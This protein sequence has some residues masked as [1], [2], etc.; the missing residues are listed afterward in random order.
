VARANAMPTH[1]ADRPHRPAHRRW[2]GAAW[3]CALLP[4]WA[5]AQG[6]AAPVGALPQVPAPLR[7]GLLPL[8]A[9]SGPR[10]APTAPQNAAVAEVVVDVNAQAAMAD[11]VSRIAVSVRLNDAS[12]QPLRTPAM[13]T[14]ESS[15]GRILLPGAGTDESGPGGL[16]ADRITPGVQVLVEGGRANFWLIAPGRPQDVLLRVSA[17]AAVAEG[18]VR[19]APELREMVAAGLV[20]GVIAMRNNAGSSIQPVRINDGFEQ[21]I[22]NWARSFDNDKGAAA[23][24]AAFFLKGKIKGDALL[25]MAYDSD[26]ETQTRLFRDVLPDQFYPVYGDASIKGSDAQS[27][28]KLYVRIDKDRNYLLY[29]DFITSASF[30]PLATPLT[31]PLSGPLNGLVRGSGLMRLRDLGNYSRTVTG[32]QAH[33]EDDRG[34][35]NAFAVNQ[36][37]RVAIEEYAANGTSGPFAVRNSAAV[38]NSEKVELITRD[39]NN[40][41]LILRSVPLAPL[42]DYVF[43][44]FSGRILLTRPLPS[45]DEVGNP[46]SLR[47]T[48]EVEQGGNPFWVYGVDGQYRV[49]P[50]LELGGSFVD[51]RNP[52]APYRLGSVNT[53]VRIGPNTQL[54][55]ELARS[56]GRYN[57]GTGVD[58][59]L[60]PGL[61][62]VSGEAAGNAA[63]IA[64][65]HDDGTTAV[66]L[67][68]GRSQK[69]FDNP[70]ASYNGGRSDA[71][72]RAT[73]RL[74]P[75]TTLFG[76]AVRTENV[77]AGGV[78]DGAQVGGAFRLSDK[79]SVDVALK[80]LSENGLPVSPSA[81]IPGNPSSAV[82]TATSP[83]TPSGGFFGTGTNPLNPNTGTSILAPQTAAPNS[84]AGT[85]LQATTVQLGAAYRLTDRLSLAGEIE[86][87][88]SGDDQKRL[89]VGAGYQLSER[90]R[91][92]GRFETQRGLSSVYSLSPA[93]RSTWFVF[94]A[95]TTFDTGTQFYSEYRLRDGI[96]D[97]LVARDAQLASGLRNTW[98]LADGLRLVTG[99]EYLKVMAGPGPQALALVGAIDYTADPLWKG[100]ARLEWRRIWDS[101]ATTIDERQDSWLSTVVLARK[102]D[103]DW[104]LLARNYFL[105]ADFAASGARWQDR[106]QIGV[107]YRDTDRNRVNALAKYEYLTENDRSALPSPVVGT[108]TQPSKRSVNMVS[109]LAD[110][111]PSR[112]WWL[113]GRVAGKTANETFDGV[114]APRYS[115]VLMSGRA[116]Y[117]VNE[118]F[119]VGVLAGVLYSP[120][121]PTRQGAIG[122]EIGYI[123]QANLR[124]GVGYNFSGFND[125]DMSGSDYTAQGV[126]LR[127][128]FKFD[129]NLFGG[130]DP[131]VNRSL[132]RPG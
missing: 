37:L 113:S 24:R 125:R 101:D 54:V 85:P 2:R 34:Y 6:T 94:G 47:I 35:G 82:G 53:G 78:R 105:H 110:W 49:A 41:S 10:V 131:N 95:D 57:T 60:T 19:F 65:Q 67:Y 39:R 124:L 7:D 11:G 66:R 55:A 9:P 99:A 28:S 43:E 81:S 21:D 20:E 123:V 84:G 69:E 25:T 87:S 106:F 70:A 115:A 83:L 96:G 80:Y 122:F 14:I 74:N 130:S 33:V 45:R 118:R 4:H 100:L 108:P 17:G 1:R 52:L 23:A 132:D 5:L 103:R 42:I 104:T 62:D 75:D 50:N 63:R 13:I 51:D 114:A 119:D 111:H 126:F 117:D 79:L 107:A 98:A 64:L 89:A 129:E 121:G 71:G 116:V 68:A 15:A 58:G 91:L 120:Q 92:Y 48:Y 31:G 29:G 109:V 40:V 88:V 8:G 32:A 102:L 112:P 90:S 61:A 128:R 3:V 93:D 59:A 22:R 36:N 38:I 76:E 26:K 97:P 73:H 56:E 12:G 27:A 86:H 127:M 16:D 18:A 46:R 30:T 44:P 77:V 72:I